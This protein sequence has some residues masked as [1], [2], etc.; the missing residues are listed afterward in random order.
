MRVD[1]YDVEH[2][3]CTLITADTGARMLIDCGHNSSTRWRPS[4]HLPVAGIK[5]IEM[6]VVTKMD[7]D[8]VSDLPDL[9]KTVRLGF[10]HRNPSITPTASMAMKTDGVPPDISDFTSMLAVYTG[11]PPQINWG[12]LTY[13]TFWNTYGSPF[14]DTNNLSLVLF[15]HYFG[16]HMVFPGDLEKEGWRLILQRPEFRAELA[17]VN[18]FVASLHG[19]EGGSCEEVFKNCCSP[20][21]VIMS[22]KATVHDTQQTARWY[23][24]RSRGIKYKG[25]TRHVFTTR[26]DGKITIDATPDGRA[27]IST[28]N[29]VYVLAGPSKSHKMS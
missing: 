29:G 20:A 18:V 19:R 17:R 2:G 3:G 11:G 12:H 23:R 27:I 26:R 14:T 25:Q 13:S 6:F 22:N 28:A 9:R 15:V 16:L 8:H 24:Q 4:V 7:N 10:L 21:V 5:S 1:L